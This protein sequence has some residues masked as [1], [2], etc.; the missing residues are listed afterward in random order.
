VSKSAARR[1]IELFPEIES[2]GT[3]AGDTEDLHGNSATE[4]LYAQPLPL[5]QSRCIWIH[6]I[7][8]ASTAAADNSASL[9]SRCQTIPYQISLDVMTSRGSQFFTEAWLPS[10][11]TGSF[12]GTGSGGL[13][14]F[15]DAFP[16][17]SIFT[18]PYT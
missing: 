7:W 11:Y 16:M 15:R 9:E 14:G 2:L 8:L 1:S 12:L 4:H 3:A 13:N 18:D 10:N 5:L 6:L 17:S